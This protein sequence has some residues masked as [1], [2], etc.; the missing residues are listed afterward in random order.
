MKKLLG[1]GLLSLFVLAACGGSDDGSDDRTVVC[2]LDEG[3]ITAEV[4]DG[5]VVELTVDAEGITLTFTGDQLQDFGA[6]DLSVD[7]FIEEMEAEGA[8]CN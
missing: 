7:G 4:E 2:T 5:E 3:T 8:N 6:E 1:I